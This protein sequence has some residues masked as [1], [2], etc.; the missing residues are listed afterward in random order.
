MDN[1]VPEDAQEGYL[2]GQCP[3][4]TSIVLEEVAYATSSLPFNVLRKF[5]CEAGSCLTVEQQLIFML[6][7]RKLPKSELE[8]QSSHNER[9]SV[10]L[11]MLSK[12]DAH[13]DPKHELPHAKLPSKKARRGRVRKKARKNRKRQRVLLVRLGARLVGEL[14]ASSRQ[15][16]HLVR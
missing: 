13:R 4:K 7:H 5:L 14:R 2:R 1:A 11:W 9:S 3:T 15:R 10:H 16:A 6:S 12:S 8:G